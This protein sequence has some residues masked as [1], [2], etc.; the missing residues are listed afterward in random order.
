M[1]KKLAIFKVNGQ[2]VEQIEGDNVNL[3]EI[4]TIKT[5]LSVKHGV[6]YND[7]EV[8]VKDVFEPELSQNCIV[9]DVGLMYRVDRPYAMFVKVEGLKRSIKKTDDFLE[10]SL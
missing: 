9:T 7:I 4:E 6:S 5:C 1:N 10:V 2:A 3:D 8:D